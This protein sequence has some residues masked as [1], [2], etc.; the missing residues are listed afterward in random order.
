[1]TCELCE[2]KLEC[3]GNIISFLIM[4]LSF[5]FGCF[6]NPCSLDVGRRTVYSKRP[7]IVK[8]QVKVVDENEQSTTTHSK[9][10]V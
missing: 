9:D 3:Y 5:M 7:P 1:M 6:C 2:A 10:A 4:L 8:P